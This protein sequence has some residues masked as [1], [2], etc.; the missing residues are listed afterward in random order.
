M[1]DH[2]LR[3]LDERMGHDEYDMFRAIPAEEIGWENPAHHMTYDEWR[4]YLQKSI[5]QEHESE[6][7]KITFV[8][9]L[10]DYPIGISYLRLKRTEDGDVAYCVRPI[11]RGKGLGEVMLSLTIEEAK[12]RDFQDLQAFANKYNVASWKTLE[13]CGFCFIDETEWGSKKYEFKLR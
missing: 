4:E 2:Y 12:K 7:P 5:A 11:C 10:G 1:T 13:K 6:N 3:K 8:M 9:Y